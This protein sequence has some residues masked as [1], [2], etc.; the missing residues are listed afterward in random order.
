MFHQDYPLEYY[1]T[2]VADLDEDINEENWDTVAEEWDSE[3]DD[4]ASDETKDDQNVSTTH[5]V[6][7]TESSLGKETPP[8]KDELLHD[9][10]VPTLLTDSDFSNN[11]FLE[12]QVEADSLAVEETSQAISEKEPITEG[13]EG[14][15]EITTRK[16]FSLQ[17]IRV[18][19]R[20][21]G[22]RRWKQ[23]SQTKSIH[24]LESDLKKETVQVAYELDNSSERDVKEG[25]NEDFEVNKLEIGDG[26]RADK[27]DPFSINDNSTN[28]KLVDL[29]SI[30]SVAKKE[31]EANDVEN[32]VEEG[33]DA[34]D[35]DEE[36][37]GG[38]KLNRGSGG[39]EGAWVGD[40]DKGQAGSGATLLPSLMGRQQQ[41]GREERGEDDNGHRE[42][43]SGLEHF[44]RIGATMEEGLSL[45][46]E[47][48]PTDDSFLDS[49]VRER[50]FVKTRYSSASEKFHPLLLRHSILCILLVLITF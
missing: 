43:G 24:L 41:G 38:V 45:L 36:E 44:L 21:G 9:L 29:T 20:E 16:S 11:P 32:E 6:E 42:A 4:S 49:K 30:W 37:A 15:E 12:E 10:P 1:T 19:V 3:G 40:S 31:N 46:A 27:E 39:I 25:D 18:T 13:E 34:T 26:V 35:S 22:G 2:T 48:H 17:G 33:E 28:L 5:N 7:Q 47:E 14:E 8:G 50:N 23:G